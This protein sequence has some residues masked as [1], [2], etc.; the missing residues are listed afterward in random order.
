MPYWLGG[1]SGVPRRRRAARAFPRGKLGRGAELPNRKDRDTPRGRV[2]SDARRGGRGVEL[3]GVRGWH[4]ASSEN[5]NIT[6]PVGAGKA[7][8]TSGQHRKV[9][10]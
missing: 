1:G 4:P 8:P 6:G 9:G 10:A 5:V 7:R 3:G 2:G